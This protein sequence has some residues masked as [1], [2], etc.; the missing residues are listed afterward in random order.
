LTDLQAP[1]CMAVC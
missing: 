1:L